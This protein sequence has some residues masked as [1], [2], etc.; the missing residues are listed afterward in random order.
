MIPKHGSHHVA[1]THDTELEFR[2]SRG[3]MM[4][5]LRAYKCRFQGGILDQ[6]F[7]VSDNAL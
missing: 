6:Y 5:P 3:R 2:R 4:F 1:S 7:T